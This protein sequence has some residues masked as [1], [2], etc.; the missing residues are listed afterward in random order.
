MTDPS[1]MRSP[2]RSADAVVSPSTASITGMML[3]DLVQCERRLHHDL[4]SDP[5]LRDKVSDFVR[6]LCDGGST[7]E[8][9]I[10]AGLQGAVVDLRAEPLALRAKRPIAR[11]EG[12]PIGSWVAVSNSGTA[13]AIPTCYTVWPTSGSRAT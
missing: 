10:L 11:S 9:A 8:A 12:A 7:H 6:M 5:A 3:R 1:N 2:S 13:S 4:H